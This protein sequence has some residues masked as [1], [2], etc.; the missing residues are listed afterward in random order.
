ML[1]R[2]EKIDIETFIFVH[3]QKIILNYIKSNRLNNLDNLKFVYLGLGDISNVE[4]MEEVIICRNLP[5]NIE[6]YPF[7]VSFT[8][9]YALWKNNLIKAEYINLFEYDIITTPQFSLKQKEALYKKV[10]IIGYI[11]FSINH[12]DY[13][14]P[15]YVDDLAESI[16]KN[17][18]IDI[19]S[20]LDSFQF[21]KLCSITSNH[22]FRKNTFNNYMNWMEPMI[23][24]LKDS[25]FCGH[26]VE[27][28]ISFFYFCHNIKR[29]PSSL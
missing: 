26:Q 20:L 10:E 5:V 3:D 18:N 14:D 12:K 17:Y 11:F 15:K 13:L 16:R 1:F 21:N 28:S 29:Y 25:I 6:Q 27:R 2:K 8:G 9:W 22:T 19:I 7:F 23:G 24:D 4:N